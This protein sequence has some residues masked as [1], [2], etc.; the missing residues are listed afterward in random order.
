[1][2]F[3]LKTEIISGG[4][5][6]SNKTELTTSKSKAKLVKRKE[7]VSN[8]VSKT[9]NIEVKIAKSNTKPLEAGV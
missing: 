2:N 1:M 6:M 4:E 8:T 3:D 5:N 9:S 7:K